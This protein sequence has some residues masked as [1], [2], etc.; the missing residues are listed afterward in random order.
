MNFRIQKTTYHTKN[1]M[2]CHRVGKHKTMYEIIETKQFDWGRRS[3]YTCHHGFTDTKKCA[4]MLILSK[5]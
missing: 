4:N 1:C 2:V 3:F 5:I